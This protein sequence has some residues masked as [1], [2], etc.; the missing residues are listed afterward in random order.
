MNVIG[1][2]LLM[3]DAKS[4]PYTCLE[5]GTFP[6]YRDAINFSQFAISK[7]D[8]FWVGFDENYTYIEV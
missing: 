6:V 7:S 4:N 8:I 5:R 1:N 2:Y 3:D